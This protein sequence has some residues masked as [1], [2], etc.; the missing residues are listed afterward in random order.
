MAAVLARLKEANAFS[1]LTSWRRLPALP[2]WV[3]QREPGTE[4]ASPEEGVLVSDA[5]Q[6]TV[7]IGQ[8]RGP[9]V[10]RTGGFAGV[11]DIYE[12]TPPTQP[13]APAH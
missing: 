2:A 8:N 7:V 9:I 5:F 3:S 10:I 11:Y 1:Q 6:H 4:F 13:S 12:E